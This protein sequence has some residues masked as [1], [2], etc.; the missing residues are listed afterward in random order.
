MDQLGR[1]LPGLVQL[2]HPARIMGVAVG[3]GV[4]VPAGDR[5]M[6]RAAEGGHRRVVQIGP[7]TR[8]RHFLAKNVPIGLLHRHGLLLDQLLAPLSNFPVVEFSGSDYTR[9][10][11]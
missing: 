3:H 4:L 5:P 9:S 6:G 2:P 7:L 11:G 1:P 10:K 8:D